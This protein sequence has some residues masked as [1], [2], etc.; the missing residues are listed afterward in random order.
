MSIPIAEELE[1]ELA[2]VRLEA[3]PP[4]DRRQAISSSAFVS[5]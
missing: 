2:R 1:V 3:A 5:A 4:D